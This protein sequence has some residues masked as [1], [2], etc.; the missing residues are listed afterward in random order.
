MKEVYPILLIPDEP[1]YVVYVPDLKINT[2]GESLAEAIEMARDAIGLWGITEQ[3]AGRK[4]PKPE[5]MNL[6]HEPNEIVTLV[7]IDFDTYRKSIDNKAVRKNLTIPNWLNTEAEK[8]GVNFS[9]IL[10]EAL[11]KEL[12]LTK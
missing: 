3:D 6:S 5:T 8:A 11:I 4:I 10:Q 12:K 9:R 1:G 2:E 7:D